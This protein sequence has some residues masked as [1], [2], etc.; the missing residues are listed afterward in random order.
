[1]SKFRRGIS[2]VTRSKC[3]GGEIFCDANGARLWFRSKIYDPTI[4]NQQDRLFLSSSTVFGAGIAPG[5]T[6]I[7][8]LHIFKSFGQNSSPRQ[9]LGTLKRAAISGYDTAGYLTAV[10]MGLIGLGYEVLNLSQAHPFGY[11]VGGDIPPKER[12]KIRLRIRQLLFRAHQR[13]A[14]K[15]SVLVRGFVRAGYSVFRWFKASLSIGRFISLRRKIKHLD[16]IIY[17]SGVTLSGAK[18][19]AKF[20][21]KHGAK[22]IFTFHGSDVRPAYL[23]GAYW[24]QKRVSVR[25]ISRQV[26][27]QKKLVTFAENLADLIVLWSGGTHFFS[28]P[29]I[30]HE[31]VGFPLAAY[32]DLVTG[33]PPREE[34]GS[35]EFKSSMSPR[36]LHMPT[37]PE[38]KGSREIR[39]IVE[40]LFSE[41]LD[42]TFVEIAG[43]S[44]REA[45]QNLRTADIVVDQIFSD[46]ASG[47]LAAEAGLLGVP[48]IV[49][50]SQNRWFSDVLGSDLPATR[51]VSTSE[52]KA[53][54]R[55]LIL[56]LEARKKA[57]IAARA[58]FEKTAKPSTVVLNLVEL[59]DGTSK[60]KT[61]SALDFTASRGGFAPVEEISE[62][63]ALL[64]R[65]YGEESLGLGH[66]F[67]LQQEVVKDYL[68]R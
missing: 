19:E 15:D 6:L 35:S 9:K 47:V 7:D 17:N 59:L 30:F 26:R 31:Q 54:L 68:T 46:S 45:I 48:V 39:A 67:Q 61:S 33:G 64:I 21:K 42:F 16:L 51:F 62:K 37:S 38:A 3:D 22:V 41:G 40:E 57:A 34:S 4:K 20:A 53:T 58:Y 23:N 2:S 29:V 60:L 8:V 44:H 66:N 11:S 5:T 25:Q 56:N 63:V 10:E 27:A 1:M 36:V 65:T 13:V 14:K 50:G 43:V 32:R 49:A 28:G 52:V 12:K 55:E 18:F 24:R